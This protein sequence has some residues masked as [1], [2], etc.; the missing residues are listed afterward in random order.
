MSLYLG[1][2]P[3]ATDGRHRITG[4]IGYMGF[5]SLRI[6]ESRTDLGNNGI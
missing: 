6:D 4:E 2:I 3:I 5:D 1:A